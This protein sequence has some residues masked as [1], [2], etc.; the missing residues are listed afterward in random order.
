M[1]S[2]NFGIVIFVPESSGLCFSEVG[3]IH[4]PCV[5]PSCGMS[6]HTVCIRSECFI[7][8]NAFHGV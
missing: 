7:R 1:A 3:R 4:F 8:N 2:V 6:C 5:I